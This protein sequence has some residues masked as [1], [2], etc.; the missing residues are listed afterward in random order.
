MKADET[1]R[2]P[3]DFA[4][5]ER[6]VRTE[7]WGKLKRFAGRLPF[8]EDLVAAYYCAL[9]SETP[10]RVRGMLLGALAYFILPG[11]VVPDIILGLGF[12]DDAAV[13]ATVIGLVATH[14]KPKHRY[15]AAKALETELPGTAKAS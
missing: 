1:F 15:A 13:L 9:D 12:T 14:I 2:S 6:K 7:F 4:A 3:R 11:D 5:D 8:A 10:L